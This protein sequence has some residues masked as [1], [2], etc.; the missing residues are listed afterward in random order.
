MGDFLIKQEHETQFDYIKRIITSKLD[1]TIDIDYVTLS[2]PVFG[3]ELSES[4]CRK[5]MYGCKKLLD[6]IEEQQMNMVSNQ[7]END[8]LEKI[9][10]EKYE[11]QKEKVKVQTETL[12][13]K[14]ITREQA[15]ADLFEEKVL[16]AI[17][18]RIKKI[19]IPT[20]TILKTSKDSEMILT[21]TDQHYGTEFKIKGM[22]G[23][24][25]NEYS[26]EVFEKRMWEVLDKTVSFAEKNGFDSVKLFD[27]GDNIDGLLHLGQLMSL[28]WGA[29]DS[30]IL[31]ADFMETW[32]N[33][34]SKYLR[35]DIYRANGNHDEL[36]LLSGKKGDFPQ[37]NIGKIIT[38]IIKKGLINNPNVN[39]IEQN[40]VGCIYTKIA[41]FDVLAVHGQNEK[42]G[43]ESSFK[44]YISNYRLNIDYLL[45]GHLHSTTL[46]EIG[47]N[48]EIIQSPSLV[49][50][51]EYAQTIKKMS[52]AGAKIVVL[53]QGYGREHE[54]NIIL[55]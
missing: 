53:T 32:I 43:L 13:L 17:K 2:L 27:L 3:Q 10:N 28:R 37:E 34:L 26:P 50:T 21:I 6:V 30:A 9:K 15:R 55:K 48:Q 54:H 35:V 46:K 38:H 19:T 14:Q 1:K 11:L 24:I 52:N 29:T 40:P 44:N 12:F 4:E 31:Y 7:S 23:E 8:I 41:G 42:G 45:S 18:N 22:L 49:G 33:E 51:N 25:I 39:V 5:R 20:R 47:I 36:R 16:E